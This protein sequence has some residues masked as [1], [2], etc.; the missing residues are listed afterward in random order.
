MFSRLD[1]MGPNEQLAY[2]VRRFQP[3]LE[4]FSHVRGIVL[5]FGAEPFP[6]PSQRQAQVVASGRPNPWTGPVMLD[7]A[8]PGPRRRRTFVV[9]IEGGKRLVLPDQVD[10]VPSRW[11]AEE[12]GWLDWGL[13][14]LGLPLSKNFVSKT[15][16]VTLSLGA[17]DP[18]VG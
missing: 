10:L 18:A 14:R 9:P 13:Q 15:G 5:S 4:G 8:L 6:S 17:Y 1:K 11:Y 7:R 2:L 12:A 3:E 16:S